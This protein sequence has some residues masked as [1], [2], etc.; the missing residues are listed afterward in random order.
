MT[1]VTGVITEILTTPDS[2]A[3]KV[4]VGGAYMH[5]AL[6]LL[7]DARVGDV[8]LVESGVALAIHREI[9]GEETSHVP[10]NSG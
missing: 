10:G 3:A 7:P 4:R 9:N 5:A 6:E 8:V 2:R 1:L